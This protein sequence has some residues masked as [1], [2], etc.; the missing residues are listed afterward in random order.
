MLEHF[1]RSSKHLLQLRQAPFAAIIDSLADQFHRLG[2]TR[3]YSRKILWIVGKLNDHARASGVHTAEIENKSLL[4]CFVEDPAYRG[5]LV[6]TAMQHFWKHLCAQGIVPRMAASHFDDPCEPIL[7]KY[8]MHLGNVRGL[9]LSSR[10]QSL[11]YAR[12]FLVWLQNRHGDEFLDFLNGVDVLEYITELA[13]CHPSGSW[14]NSLC[15]YTCGF[16][17]YLRWQ[18]I[19]HVDLDRVVPKLPQRRLRDIPRHLPWEQVRRLIASVDTRKPIGL[20]DKAV[21]LLI[22]VL[23][24]RN[25]EVRALQL[26][27]IFWRTGEIRLKKTKTRRERMLPLPGQVGAAIADYLLHG[28]PRIATPHVFLRHFTPV[29]PITSTHGVGDIVKKHLLRA[30]IR[31]SNH[32]AHLLRHS[33]ATRM[34]NQEVPIKQIADMLGHA[35]IDTTAI[36]TK[37]DTTHLAAVALPFPGGEL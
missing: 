12:R 25:Q 11:R 37:V 14:R 36:Y 33:L 22:A 32:G 1:Y 2:Y 6:P 20:R 16:L 31:A 3:K 35:S 7:H 28:R 17:R 34:V 19:I 9:V 26:T 27:D 5:T 18:G 30:G 4:Q 29:G 8:D 10:T 13:G 21:M 23:G 15:S 24:L